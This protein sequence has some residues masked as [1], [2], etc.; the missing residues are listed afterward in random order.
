MKKGA[1]VLMQEGNAKH[2]KSTVTPCKEPRSFRL[3]LPI[4]PKLRGHSRA[5]TLTGPPKGPSAY[6]P[7]IVR[8]GRKSGTLVPRVHRVPRLFSC[9]TSREYLLGDGY[10][11]CHPRRTLP[12]PN[13]THTFQFRRTKTDPFASKLEKNLHKDFLEKME[14]IHQLPV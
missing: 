11:I 2:L 3:E 10:E 5:P 8:R 6:A 1:T 7:N 12:Q 4:G 13:T 9:R 14:F